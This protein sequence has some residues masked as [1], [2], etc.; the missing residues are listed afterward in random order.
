M[1][2]IE[3]I[4][5][6]EVLDSRGN[7]TVEVEVILIDGSFG[8]AIVPSGASTGEWEALELRDGDK[9]RYGGKG[10]LRAVD[11]VNG[12]IA[13]A[14][15]GQYALNQTTIDQLMIALDGT[16]TKS[17][18]G[19]NAILGVSLA[20]AKAAANFAEL[21]LYAYIGGVHAHVLPVP[22]MNIMNGGKHAEGSTDFQEFMVMPVGA[23]T[24]REGLQW[25]VEIYQALKGI[26]HSKGQP[27]TVGDEGGFA[28]SLGSNQAAL[29]VIMEAII[30]AGY[31][32]G[33]Q[34]RIALDPA[35]SELYRDGAYHLDIE[36][37][38]LSGAEMV[39]FWENWVNQYPIISIED[40]LAE[41]DWENWS[42]LVSTIGNRV[43]IVGDDLL[44]TNVEKVKRA[45]R[46]KAANALL[47]KLNQIGSLTEALAAAQ[48]SQRHNMT[49]I[50]SHRSGES[51]DTTVADVAVAMNAGQIKTGAPTRT[52]RVA[53]YNQLLRIEEEL[54]SAARY[55]GLSAFSN[56]GLDL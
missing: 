18:L 51:E 6:R 43:Q 10:V 14:L 44:V 21:P 4:H 41:N 2:V 31:Q 48:L 22:M 42:A 27:T 38:V 52:D 20:V 16:P 1:S 15:H 40:G 23:S 24:F 32:P 37:K 5:G 34:I 12:P 33:T 50:A 46:E 45:L 55:A 28:P 9:S 25:G 11:A 49:V 35:V 19:A 36:G 26:L 17:S 30:K 47:F 53:K 56:L 3:R 39:S 7:P 54:G 13:D 29:D 8:R